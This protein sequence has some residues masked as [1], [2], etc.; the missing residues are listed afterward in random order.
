MMLSTSPLTTFLTSKSFPE[1]S[2]SSDSLSFFAM[3]LNDNDPND[4]YAEEDAYYGGPPASF[5]E[6]N[7]ADPGAST[8]P[9]MPGYPW[10]QYVDTGAAGVAQQETVVKHSSQSRPIPPTTSAWQSRIFEH[11]IE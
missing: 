4:L 9:E 7:L 5:S 11:L 10:M 1:V 6:S 3:E 8:P 2:R